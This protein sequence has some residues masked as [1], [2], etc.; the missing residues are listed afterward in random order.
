MCLFG[1]VIVYNYMLVNTQYG[2]SALMIAAMKGRGAVVSL[3][4][5]AG[6]NVDLQNKV[7]EE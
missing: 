3:L 5:E 1:E 2:H 6:A 7:K 4:L